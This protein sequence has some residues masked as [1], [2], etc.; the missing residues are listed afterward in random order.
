MRPLLKA[1][2]ILLVIVCCNDWTPEECYRFCLSRQVPLPQL[3]LELPRKYCKRFPTNTFISLTKIFLTFANK[4]VYKIMLDLW[5]LLF[6]SEKLLHGSPPILIFLINFFCPFL[7]RQH[8]H[9]G[10][11]RADNFRCTMHQSINESTI[12]V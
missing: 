3:R 6:W 7:P 10:A 5:N 1:M 2:S 4:Y 11:Y 8:H 12:A 9:T